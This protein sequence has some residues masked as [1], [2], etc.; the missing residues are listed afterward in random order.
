MTTILLLMM[1][2]QDT[3]DLKIEREML[4]GMTLQIRNGERRIISLFKLNLMNRFKAGVHLGK[5][6]VDI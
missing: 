3:F 5:E 1:M 2:E 4:I 6:V